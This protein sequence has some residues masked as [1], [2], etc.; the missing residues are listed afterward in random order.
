MKKRLLGLIA[1]ILALSGQGMAQT[2]GQI[3]GVQTLPTNCTPVPVAN[4]STNTAADIVY[5]VDVG[6]YICDS[7]NHWTAMANIAVPEGLIPYGT[8]TS[9][10]SSINL[11]YSAVDSIIE[12]D[13]AAVGTVYH[14]GL[15]LHGDTILYFRSDPVNDTADTDLYI[16]L[17]AGT[18]QASSS[19]MFGNIFVG[20][21]VGQSMATGNRNTVVGNGSLAH[22]TGGDDNVGVGD[23]TLISL[24]TGNKNVHL[25]S[26]AGFTNTGDSNVFIGY[27]TAWANG[28]STGNK[29]IAVGGESM[30]YNASGGLTGSSNVGVGWGVLENVGAGSGNVALGYAAGPTSNTSNKLFINNAE[31]DTPLIGGDF[32]SP[33][34][35]INGDFTI[36]ALKTTGAA[37]G[38]KIV[39]VDTL[40]GK[41]Y[42]S[43][44][45]DTCAN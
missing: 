4:L 6:L 12:L 26:Q 18:V 13:S 5:L 17:G 31:S 43:S 32:G 28:A 20:A 42:A 45:N 29:N 25:G 3:R 24:V 30:G 16:G 8:G 19:T 10:A 14:A 35:N 11:A 37:T 7:P 1:L 22:A 9:L 21:Q 23:D 39:C 41:L 38:K 2:A 40:T 44:S 27:G 33:V 15:S 36:S 34:V